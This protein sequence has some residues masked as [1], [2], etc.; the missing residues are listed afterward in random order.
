M[1]V[2][3]ALKRGT[4]CVFGDE[5]FSRQVIGASEFAVDT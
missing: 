2:L 3:V 1:S 5:S 4:V